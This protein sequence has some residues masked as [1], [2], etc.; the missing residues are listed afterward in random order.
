MRVGAAYRVSK[1]LQVLVGG[2][3]QVGQL[4]WGQDGDQHHTGFAHRHSFHHD[5]LHP[6]DH[7]F[8][9][10]AMAVADTTNNL[11]KLTNLYMSLCV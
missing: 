5:R 11:L 4:H 10:K 3:Q 7:A 8:E 1:T 6:G 2:P 9:S